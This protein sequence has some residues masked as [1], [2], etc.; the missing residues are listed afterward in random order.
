[1]VRHA[2]PQHVLLHGVP[3][4][5][6]AAER[7]EHR[8]ADAG[9]AAA[10]QRCANIT[11]HRGS[12]YLVNTAGVPLPIFD[13]PQLAHFQGMTAW[14]MYPC[15]VNVQVAYPQCQGND[16]FLTTSSPAWMSDSVYQEACSHRWWGD[17]AAN[18]RAIRR[19]VRSRRHVRRPRCDVD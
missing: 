1:M 3:V 6:V 12:S 14:N 16:E 7:L 10:A 15:G 11:F 8:H 13:A 2:V 5:V 17:W 19:L 4:A 18:A 9:A